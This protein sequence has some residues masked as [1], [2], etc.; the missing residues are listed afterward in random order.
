[1]TLIDALLEDTS[2]L[3]QEEL[4]SLARARADL[5][6]T[7][8]RIVLEMDTQPEQA[9]EQPSDASSATET[10]SSATEAPSSA[11][12]TPA[13]EAPSSAT[14]TPSEADE[15]DASTPMDDDDLNEG[16][17]PSQLADELANEAVVAP[18]E[19]TQLE[20]GEVDVERGRQVLQQ[21]KDEVVS[22]LR[23][24]GDEE[25][26]L[27]PSGTVARIRGILRRIAPFESA[28]ELARRM[29]LILESL[30]VLFR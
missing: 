29:R 28:S 3:S 20:E 5:E 2:V 14:E 22:L 25:D 19:A 15:E 16:I 18:G 8:L 21:A 4:E 9:N 13:S 11:T 12:E 24:V 26:A 17:S 7:R 23:A 27:L 6:A 10:P 30:C 1:M